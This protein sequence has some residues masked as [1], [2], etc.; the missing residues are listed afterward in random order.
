MIKQVLI[1]LAGAALLAAI[2]SQ[3]KVP[4]RAVIAAATDPAAHWLA[5][6]RFAAV[7]TPEAVLPQQADR[8]IVSMFD[9]FDRKDA[10]FNTM[11]QQ[12]PGMK[13]AIS[14]RIRPIVINYARQTLPLYRADLSQLFQAELTTAEC[15]AAV[16]F[17]AS[18]DGQV[19]MSSLQESMGYERTAGALA[20]QKPAT[21]ADVAADKRAA[22]QQAFSSFDPA[23]RQRVT[24]FF[25]SPLGRK[26]LALGP[27]RTAIDQKWVNYSPPGADAVMQTAVLEA[28]VDH[29]GKT[30]PAKAA[31]FRA[32]LEKEGLL[33]KKPF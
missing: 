27:Q 33:P 31:Q 22:G 16:A 1:T 8:L 25:E 23:R 21:N 30:D 7:L 4:K 12:Y 9:A 28:M 18:S 29:V 15:N 32:E 10:G 3:A 20:G 17:F 6:D 13:E 24:R 5:A 19:L 11:E 26:L 2:P 14:V